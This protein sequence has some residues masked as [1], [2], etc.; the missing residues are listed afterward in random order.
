MKHKLLF[1]TLLACFTG[2]GQVT[3]L[4]ISEYVEGSSSNKYVEIYNGTGATVDLSNYKLRLYANGSATP[5]EVTLSGLL[6][7]NQAI[8][9]KNSASTIFTG[10]STV[11]TSVNFNGD[12][13]LAIYKISTNSNVDIFGVVGNDPGTAWTATGFSTV[14]KTLR[15]KINIC[16]GIS[17]SPTGTGAG[18]FTTLASEWDIFNIDDVSGLGNHTANCTVS[19]STTFTTSWSNSTPTASIDATIAGD[20]TTTTDLTCKDLTINSGKTLTIGAGKKLSV[21]GNL[22][23]NGTL[24]FKSDATGTAI[25]D[26]FSGSLSPAGSTIV[27]RYIPARRAYRF[28]SPSV[29]T[30]TSIRANWQENGGTI[31]G[32]GTHIT[33]AT[34]AS[35]GFD[36]TETNNSSLLYFNNGAWVAASNTSVNALSAGDAYCLMVRGDRTIDLSTNTPTP[37]NTVLRTMGTLF[38][39]NFTPTLS[40]VASGYSFVG[41]PYQA[42]LDIKTA[43]ATSSSNININAVYYWDPTINSRGGYITRNLQTSQNSPTSNV[44]DYV[45]PGQAFFVVNKITLTGTPSLTFTENHK[46][47]ANA[48][49]GAFRNANSNEYG[50][51]RVN[52]QANTN[53]QWQTIEGAVAIFNS[54]FN[55]AVTE[56]DATKMT[57]LDEEVS[58]VQNNTSLAIACQPNPTITS[59]LPIRLNNT[60]HTNYQWQFDIANYSGPTPFLLD[61][62]NNSITQITNTTVVPFT[63][64]TNAN[65][66]KIV[67][68]NAVL[69]LSDF[70]TQLAL[71]PNPANTGDSFYIDG[72]SEASVTVF[73]VLGQNIQVQTKSQGNSVQVTPSAILSKGVY[74]VT[75]TAQGN[76]QQ[77]KWIVE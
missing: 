53:N 76:T 8:V 60:R 74:L 5:S 51:L 17:T 25:F 35:A 38:T 22:I 45:Q 9:Y 23:N 7:N 34:G 64:D 63:A 62:Q 52:L 21:T 14:D 33:G 1:I 75:I 30:S 28:L 58:F 15:R 44:N 66:F 41:N 50:T 29:N 26:V 10:T 19:T 42:P 49:A 27:E 39:G 61:T 20:L 77:V 13:A 43:L 11:N 56:E 55:T 2:W 54:D 59:E 24:V 48:A 18:A 73:N 65:R 71:Y 31:A 32:L 40:T 68:Q 37:T 6:L 72:L 67:F 47:V 4:I 12:D 3:D 69:N 46:S 16:S 70:S 36:P 57:N